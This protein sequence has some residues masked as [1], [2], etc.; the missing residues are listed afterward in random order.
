MMLRRSLALGSLLAAAFVVACQEPTATSGGLQPT[1]SSS[2]APAQSQ[3][4]GLVRGWPSRSLS[5]PRSVPTVEQLFSETGNRTINPDQ[6]VCSDATPI[7]QLLNA[8]LS[9]TIRT[10]QTIFFT[11]YDRYADLIPTYE[12]LFFQTSATPQTFGYAGAFTQVMTKVERDV[13]AFWDIPAQDIQVVAMHGTMLADA[14]RTYQTYRLLG[15]KDK[16]AAEYA[17][18][19]RDALL[20]SKTMNG[21]NYAF[22]TFNAVSFRHPAVGKKIVMGDGIVETYATLGFADVA[23]QAIFAHEYAHQIQYEKNYFADVATL[24]G[25]EQTRYTELMADA[26]SA[27]FLTHARGE[28]LN[29]FRVEEFLQVFYQIGDC[30][31]DNDGHHGTPNQRWRAAQLGFNIADQ[32]QQ[33]GHILTSQE[34]HDLFVAEYPRIVAPDAT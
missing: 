12:A 16:T 3:N 8:E 26:M 1:K 5:L 9:N 14:A 32:Y 2:A 27:Y 17:V 31:F 22:W 11:M 6:Y 33:Q 24:D 10:E 19:V 25:P 20:A 28:A 23:P 21:G 18:A 7:I 15:L 13:K 34:F 4:A 29:K 30:A